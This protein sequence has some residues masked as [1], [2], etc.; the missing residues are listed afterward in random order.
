MKQNGFSQST[1]APCVYIQVRKSSVNIVAIY[2][3]DLIITETPEEMETI[4]GSLESKFKVKDMGR[5]HYSL[6]ISIIK[7]DD[8]EC[9]WLHQKQHILN[10][11][12][13]YGTTEANTS[14]T[15]ADVNVKLVKNDNVSK[16][17]DPVLHQSMV[18]SLLYIAWLHIL[19]LPMQWELCPSLMQ[20]LKRHTLQH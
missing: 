7:D 10:M 19:I 15:P 8:N 3:D 17:V 1:Y 4:K 12:K 9:I 11:L 13:R 14:T 6:G 20:I 16:E 5:L 18:G 2:V